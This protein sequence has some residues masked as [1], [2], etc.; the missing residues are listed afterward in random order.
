[1]GLPNRR[2][3]ETAS[4]GWSFNSAMKVA[5]VVAIIR[6]GGLDEDVGFW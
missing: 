6:L 4:T 1:M 5:F 2:I 3:G